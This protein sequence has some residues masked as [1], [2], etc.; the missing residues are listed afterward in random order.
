[1]NFKDKKLA[2]EAGKK[3]KAGKHTKTKQWEALGEFITQEGAERFANI[4]NDSDDDTFMDM[5]LK[6]L[7]Y[8]K[9]KISHNINEQVDPIEIKGITFDK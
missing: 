1:M 8:F 7:N 5:Y 6:A 4:M 9:P 2:S 3:S